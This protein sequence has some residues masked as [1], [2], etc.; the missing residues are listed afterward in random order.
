MKLFGYKLVKDNAEEKE[1]TPFSRAW[2]PG[3]WSYGSYGS[4]SDQDFEAQIDKYT[5]WVYTCANRNAQRVAAVP[6]RLYVKKPKGS[7]KRTLFPTRPINKERLDYLHSKS[8]LQDIMKKDM[9]IE[10]VVIHPL[11]ELFRRVNNFRNR[12]DLWE[13]TQLFME[14]TGNA[15]W[16]L[17]N[18][19]G[20]GPNALPT[21]LWVLPTQNVR[22]VPSK[23]K[24][25]AG[26]VYRNGTTDVPLDEYEVIHFRFPNPR[27]LYYGLSPIAAISQSI[28]YNNYAREFENTLLKRRGVPE[29]V[30]E[31]EES[32]NEA[33]FKRLKEEWNSNY[34]GFNRA[35][36]TILLEKGLSYK[37][38]TIPPKDMAN[39]AGLKFTRED[40]AGAFGQPISLITSEN[41]NKANAYAG[42]EQHARDAIE[43]RCFRI[44]EKL[45][46]KLT[47]RYDPNLFLSYDTPV[48]EDKEFRMKERAS[49]IESWYSNVNMERE[50]DRQPPVPWGDKLRLRA[51]EVMVD[52][53]NPENPPPATPQPSS[54][55]KPNEPEKPKP[56]EPEKPKKPG[57]FNDEDIAEFSS[58]VVER[59]REMLK[60]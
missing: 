3:F 35:G 60:C 52:G 53:N 8:S 4:M 40:I 54:Q 6:L 47:I 26:Y 46:E 19:K 7:I 9:E 25:I 48:P 58:R 28:D 15:Y 49:N 16:W 59:V 56:N 45:N 32:L 24:F 2:T 20:K 1:Q 39:L 37:P 27:S 23:E 11:L 10:E 13:E 44:E 33:E 21:A 57:K 55:P 41:V 38:I 51:G 18:V 43:P 22:I 29:A 5:S 42:R 50:K 17:G 31:T 14:L 30:L 34:G 36:K 12:F